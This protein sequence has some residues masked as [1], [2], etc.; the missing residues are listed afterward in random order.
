MGTK[1]IEAKL[2]AHKKYLALLGGILLV[3][4]IGHTA[5]KLLHKPVVKKEIPV[6]RTVTIATKSVDNN[7]TY[8][9]TVRGKYETNL[10]FQVAGKIVSRQV[11]LGD[12]VNAGDVLMT[13]DPKDVAQLVNSSQAAVNSASANYK[14]AADNAKRYNTL[15]KQGAVSAAINEQYQVQ[16]EAAAATLRQA[17]A[18]LAANSHQMEYTTLRAD[19]AGVIAALTGEIGMVVAAGTPVA[20]IVQEGGRE[21][22]I[23]V[24][25][26]RLATVQ[27]G[28]TCQVTFWALDNITT[29]GTVTEVA[30]MADPAT[31]TYKVKVALSAMPEAAKLGMTAK[32]NMT[33]GQTTDILLPRSAIYQTGNEPKVW[34]VDGDKVKLVSIKINGYKEDKAL[35]TSG[36]KNGDK[37][38]SGGINKLSE[39]MEV[40][41][42]E[43]A[44]S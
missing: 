10:A 3:A 29:T 17:E 7:Y 20:T 35:V 1:E 25:E 23:F 21:I 12:R 42:E 32:V 28:Q 36:L 39:N 30:P 8:P 6:V 5:Y 2:L 33:E 26:N 11:N 14:L 43:G 34:L 22:Q 19:H 27:Q 40:S 16:L 44:E 9:G 31:K 18:Q 38:V 37:V 24:P 15:Y 13:I 4:L 41:C